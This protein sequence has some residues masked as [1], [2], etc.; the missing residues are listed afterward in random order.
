MAK[1]VI[2]I[3]PFWP[4]LEGVPRT[5][6]AVVVSLMDGPLEMSRYTLERAYNGT[7][8]GA[9]IDTIDRLLALC[10]QWAGRKITYD[11]ITSAAK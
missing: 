2:N 9:N 5:I 8:K 11:E 3:R 10:S 1:R 4:K 6:N 7:L